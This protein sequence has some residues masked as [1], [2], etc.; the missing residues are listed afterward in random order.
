[1]NYALNSPKTKKIAIFGEIYPPN[2]ID[3]VLSDCPLLDKCNYSVYKPRNF[4]AYALCS[5]FSNQGQELPGRAFHI[6]D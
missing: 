3:L 4:Q 5:S 1:M 2:C 6:I